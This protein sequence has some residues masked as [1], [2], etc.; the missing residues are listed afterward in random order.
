ML[1]FPSQGP[2]EIEQVENDP[3]QLHAEP[4]CWGLKQRTP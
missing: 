3:H 4:P 1:R 2:Q